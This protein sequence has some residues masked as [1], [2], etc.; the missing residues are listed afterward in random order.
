MKKFLIVGAC[1][2]LVATGAFLFTNRS[3]S[4]KQI[5]TQISEE[6]GTVSSQKTTEEEST[7]SNNK[8]EKD[9]NEWQDEALQDV[10]QAFLEAAFSYD[11]LD[12]QREQIK[13]F[14]YSEDRYSDLGVTDG[15]PVYQELSSEIVEE[16]S[17]FREINV[18]NQE[19]LTRVHVR[20]DSDHN[21]DHETGEHAHKI[22]NQ[23]LLVTIHYRKQ[24]DT[25]FAYDL[26]YEEDPKNSQFYSN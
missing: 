20:Y 12:K 23:V 2:L 7:Q 9:T 3:T 16:T 13:A 21:H 6:R 14:A 19:V 1:V 26:T 18:E 25:W 8:K 10:H 4:E 22:T 5:E 17:Y 11:S 24:G 15:V